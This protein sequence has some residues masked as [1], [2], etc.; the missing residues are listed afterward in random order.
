MVPSGVWLLSAFCS[1][2]LSFQNQQFGWFSSLFMVSIVVWFQC[3]FHSKSIFWGFPFT[4]H[5]SLSCL[6]PSDVWLQYV[7]HSKSPFWVVPF[8]FYGSQFVWLQSAVSSTGSEKMHFSREHSY[9]SHHFLCTSLCQKSKF[10]S[11]LLNFPRISLPDYPFFPTMLLKLLNC[12]ILTVRSCLDNI[13]LG[14][15]IFN[16]LGGEC[17]LFMHLFKSDSET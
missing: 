15:G 14:T 7:F 12:W 17:L 10:P 2:V 8:T 4:F 9:I 1:R 5:G 13:E 11:K 16:H 6:V 3:V